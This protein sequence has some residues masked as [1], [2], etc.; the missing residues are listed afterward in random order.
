MHRQA[1]RHLILT[2]ALAALVTPKL[3]A[4]RV[5]SSR[6]PTDQ[7]VAAATRVYESLI[8]RLTR[9]KTLTMYVIHGN[10]TDGGSRTVHFPPPRNPSSDDPRT[11]L[12]CFNLW[13]YGYHRVSHAEYRGEMATVL[14]HIPSD[15][16]DG[17]GILYISDRTGWPIAG[18]Y[19]PDRTTPRLTEFTRL[20]VTL[21]GG[22]ASSADW[23]E[24]F[25]KNAQRSLSR[26]PR[27]LTRTRIE[28][29]IP[30]K[31]DQYVVVSP[32]VGA[33]GD[34]VVGVGSGMEAA[35]A[36]YVPADGLVRRLT[37]WTDCLV[38]Y[39]QRS[40]SRLLLG[41]NVGW[42]GNGPRYQL[43]LF[44]LS[45]G[46]SSRA[47]H[48]TTVE[49]IVDPTVPPN[50]LSGK[51]FALQCRAYPEHMNSSHATALL[52]VEESFQVRRLK[53]ERIGSRLADTAYNTLDR[54]AGAL[55]KGDETTV[56]KLVPAADTRAKLQQ[57]WKLAGPD[58][59][60]ST[61]G[62]INRVDGT[63][64]QWGDWSDPAAKIRFVR[65][66]GAWRVTSVELP[67]KPSLR[68]P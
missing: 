37:G 51:V 63:Y 16:G 11:I 29:A 8:E 17:Y 22:V 45:G 50:A 62:S 65:I 13:G 5:Q 41:G 32:V 44:T 56:A 9:I 35:A 68:E 30:K 57:A 4:S 1:G 20:R 61:P 25:R 39:A 10:F 54:L 52:L 3:T 12:D 27:P 26:T 28:R 36:F 2:M 64:Y 66:S 47:S 60:V 23:T 43:M 6:R 15:G 24:V 48:A 31:P 49:Q 55:E 42:Y 40:G 38:D 21:K 67:K 46:H 33:R 34:Y 19:A 58:P 7:E 14:E 53:V 59:S 18:G